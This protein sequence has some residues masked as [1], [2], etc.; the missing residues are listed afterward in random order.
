MI[1]PGL[2]RLKFA[3]QLASGGVQDFFLWWKHSQGYVDYQ[4]NKP[5]TAWCKLTVD[6]KRVSPVIKSNVL[7]IIRWNGATLP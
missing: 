2:T 5:E 6:G 1:Q 3:S 4:K 7:P